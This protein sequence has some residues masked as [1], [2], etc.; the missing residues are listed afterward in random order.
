MA[1][2]KVW[3]TEVTENVT[4][5]TVRI[6]E[7]KTAWYETAIIVKHKVAE[8]IRSKYKAEAGMEHDAAVAWAKGYKDP[9]SKRSE[10]WSNAVAN[11]S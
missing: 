7:G 9:T 3:R 11:L 4:V 2:T 8:P 1:T 6:R 10:H 5:S